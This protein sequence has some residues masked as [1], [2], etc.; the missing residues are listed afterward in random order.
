MTKDENGPPLT[1]STV[2]VKHLRGP[3]SPQGRL[4]VVLAAEHGANRKPAIEEQAGHGSPDR[5]GLTGC[6]RFEDRPDVGDATSLRL[7]ERVVRR[8]WNAHRWQPCAGQNKR[9]S[10]ALMI[11]LP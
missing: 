6:P 3:G 10:A 9:L 4:P 11:L 8:C 7:A 5:S 2:T 1:I